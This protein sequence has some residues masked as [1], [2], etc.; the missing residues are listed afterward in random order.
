MFVCWEFCDR[1]PGSQRGTRGQG[2]CFFLGACLPS[3]AGGRH[4]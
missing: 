2:L 1:R 3:P 4:A